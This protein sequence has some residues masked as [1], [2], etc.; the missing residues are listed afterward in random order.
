MADEARYPPIADYAAV[1]DCHGS[2]LISRAGSVDWC[3]LARFDADPVFCRILDADRGGYLAIAPSG[4]HTTERAYIDG[5]NILR[6]EFASAEGRIA[7]TDF[8]PVGRRPWTGTHNYVDLVAPHWLVRIVEGLEGRVKVGLDYRPTVAFARGEARLLRRNERVDAEDGPSL[9]TDMEFSIEGDR[10]RGEAEIGAGERRLVVVA[11]TPPTAARPLAIIDEL[12]RVTR[13]FWEEWIAYCRYDGRYRAMVRRSGLALKLLTYAPTGALAAAA[14]TSLPEE[15]GGERNWDYRYCWLRDSTLTLYALAAL[16]YGGEARAF[17]R[18]LRESCRV[19]A[20][21]LQIMYGIELQ[22]E[23]EE[24]LHEHL[25]GYRG[26]RPVR[27]GNAAYSQRQSDIYGEVVD[28]AFMFHTLGGK[29][30]SGARR[31]LESLVE[32]VA[33]EWREPDHGLW[34]MRGPPLHHVH[35]KVMGWVAVDRALSLLGA[36]RAREALREEI[37]N[38]IMARGRDGEHGHFVQ[39][40]DAHGTDAALLLIPA[41]GFPADRETL[42]KTVDAVQRELR[43]GMCVHRYRTEDGLSGDEGAFLICSFWLVDALLLLD[44]YD[45][46]RA[47]FEEL[48]AA[49]NDVGLYAE[50]I[51]P[52]DGS[53][54]GNFPQA[55]THLALVGSAFNLDLYERYGIEGL[56]GDYADRAKRGVEAILGWRAIWAACKNAGRLGRI[57]PSLKSTLSPRLVA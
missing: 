31:M 21:R 14:T 43:Q 12:L 28:W 51:D 46:A 15:I 55:F 2:A 42:E 13:A 39:A 49:A 56:K 19:T 29:L 24:Q 25:E 9:Y 16:G 48:L 1:G 11:A 35:G 23:L 34:E 36:N 52:A 47:L 6:T 27:T 22:T 26:S 41:V 5:T 17:S 50:E 37:F 8:M 57:F 45:E 3:A 10:V 7:V 53:F 38:D 40:Y 44:R 4:Q 18:F 32:T 20:P 54:L 33:R 30:D